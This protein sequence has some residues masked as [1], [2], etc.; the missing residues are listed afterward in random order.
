[1]YSDDQKKA[2]KDLSTT[3]V[4]SLKSLDYDARVGQASGIAYPAI[5][6]GAWT[7]ALQWDDGLGWACN[8]F[9]KIGGPHWHWF[10]TSK[11]DNFGVSYATGISLRLFWDPANPKLIEYVMRYVCYDPCRLPYA[12]CTPEFICP[13]CSGDW[14]NPQDEPGVI[15][16]FMSP[17]IR[18]EP[19]SAI[20]TM[21]DWNQ[22]EV[23]LVFG[24]PHDAN[25]NTSN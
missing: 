13:S 4:E 8:T 14:D 21:E 25:Q 20:E 23:M 3:V 6:Y 17:L 15:G 1:M 5:R 24:P 7:I 9:E 22:D 10:L 18:L 2:F 12:L 11:M 19:D 16:K